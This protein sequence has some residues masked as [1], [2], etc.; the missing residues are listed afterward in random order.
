MT[1]D[2]RINAS[3]LVLLA[4]KLCAEYHQGSHEG[5][6]D[7]RQEVFNKRVADTWHNFIPRTKY[8]VELAQSAKSDA[9]EV[10]LWLA[11]ALCS[12]YYLG[13]HES[14]G[15]QRNEVYKQKVEDHWHRWVPKAREALLEA[16]PHLE[17]KLT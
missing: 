16:F 13:W 15:D 14:V 5:V 17:G 3:A 10:L 6:N 12:E 11:K 2:E 8:A 1:P 9:S 4:K 7:R